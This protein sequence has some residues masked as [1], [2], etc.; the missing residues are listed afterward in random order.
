MREGHIYIQANKDNPDIVRVQLSEPMPET[1]DSGYWRTVWIGLFKDCDAGLMHSQNML[2]R[3]LIDIDERTYQVPLA[4]AIA[5]IET[6]SLS[7]SRIFLDDQFTP[8]MLA[9]I[10]RWEKYYRRRQTR[11]LFFVRWLGYIAVAYLLFIL[12]F[13]F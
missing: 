9:E 1:G 4:K 13:G 2:C 7:H 11:F 12:L 8:E 5:A 10:Q 3:H 6:D